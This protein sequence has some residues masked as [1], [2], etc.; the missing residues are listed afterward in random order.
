MKYRYILLLA[1]LLIGGAGCKKNLSPEEQFEQD[2]NDIEDY[3]EK[4]NLNAQKTASGLYYV[5]NNLGTGN[6]PNSNDNVTVRY[7]GYLLDGT[8]FDQSQEEGITFNL[9]QV[10]EGW[11]EGIP[12][13]K[14]GGSGILIIPSKLGYKNKKQGKIPA[15]SVLIFEVDLLMIQH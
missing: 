14:E 13:Y 1:L 8:V 11:T 5:I 7:K 9:Q 12:K 4:N 10:I 2:I 6:H 3:I 15:N